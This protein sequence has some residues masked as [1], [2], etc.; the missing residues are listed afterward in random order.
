MVT[1]ETVPCKHCGKSTFML[2]TRECEPHWELRRRIEAEP[3]VAV[4]MLNGY[5]HKLIE[6]LSVLT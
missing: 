6:R 5:Q 3:E 2:G 4:Q 1:R